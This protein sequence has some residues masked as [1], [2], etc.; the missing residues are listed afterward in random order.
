MGLF[1]VFILS[2]LPVF[3]KNCNEK[4]PCHEIQCGVSTM[5]SWQGLLLPCPE[6]LEWEA[7]P[8]QEHIVRWLRMV[9]PVESRID[10]LEQPA[11][12]GP[13]T[14]ASRD[15]NPAT[16]L[17]VKLT[18]SLHLF[19]QPVEAQEPRTSRITLAIFVIMV[20]HR[21]KGHLVCGL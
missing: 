1:R 3:L 11:R 21:P 9:L 15:D 6:G 7:Q 20:G 18:L 4:R 16:L 12:E 14:Y 13:D 17:P 10:F 8:E 19:V 5:H 2:I